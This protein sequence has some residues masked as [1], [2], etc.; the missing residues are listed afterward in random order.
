MCRPAAGDADDHDH[1]R[2][3]AAPTAAETAEDAALAANMAKPPGHCAP[4]AAPEG[5]RRGEDCVG[6][7]PHA[8]NACLVVVSRTR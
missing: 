6:E 1:T 4:T 7:G 8:S 2:Q 3:V 5:F